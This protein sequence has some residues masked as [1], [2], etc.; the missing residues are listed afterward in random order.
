[1]A[2]FLVTG[3]GGFIGSNLVRYLLDKGHSVRGI[4]NFITGKRENIDEV[5]DRFDFIESDVTDFDTIMQAS[6]DMDYVLHQA[7]LPSV[8]RSVKDPIRSNDINVGGTVRVL[9]AARAHKVKRVVYAASSSAYGDQPSRTK[10]ETQVPMPLS[11]YAVSKLAG[12]YYCAAY[13]SCFNLET[14]CLRY[15]NIF[16]PRQDP[17]SQYS[18]VIPK[19]VNAVLDDEQPVIYGDGLQSRDFT[20]VENACSANLL[21]A[22]SP[23]VGAGEVINIA[24]GS[25]FDLL[26]LLNLIKEY[27]GKAEIEPR[28]D[29]PRP[30]DVRHSLAD[31]SKARRLLG[32]EVL[33]PFEEGL[34]RTVEWYRQMR[35]QH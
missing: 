16:G 23:E 20:F 32:Y 2:N 35:E 14:V 3:A 4:D 22:Q 11:P 17:K 25:N 5:I 27:T 12:E 26:T 1:V 29:P 13:Y 6:E 18:A 10:V 8:P 31:I 15:F 19:F 33:V 24:C 9:D 30:G 28:F 34:R 21:A 7:A